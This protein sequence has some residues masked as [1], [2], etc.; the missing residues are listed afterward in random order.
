MAFFSGGTIGAP[1]D[2]SK[3]GGAD[4][5]GRKN[6]NNAPIIGTA[7]PRGQATSDLTPAPPPS[8]LAASSDAYGAARGA[9]DKQRKRAA[10]GSTLVGGVGKPGGP[11]AL[12][13]PKTLLG[14]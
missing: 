3:R 7:V 11:T 5:T 8:T 6:V 10:A 12:L 9:A 1:R 14:S 4:G 2:P 13:Q